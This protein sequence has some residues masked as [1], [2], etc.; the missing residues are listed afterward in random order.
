MI[1]FYS[2]RKAIPLA[3]MVTDS[4]AGSA[5][6]AR[7]DDMGCEVGRLVKKLWDSPEKQKEYGFHSTSHFTHTIRQ[8]LTELSTQA[9]P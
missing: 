4:G 5:T 8:S 6:S 1:Q 7:R 9:F 2:D 3:W